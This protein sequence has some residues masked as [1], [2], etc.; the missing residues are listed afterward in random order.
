MAIAAVSMAAVPASAD[1]GRGKGKAH[2]DHRNGFTGH[3]PPGLAKKNPPCVPPGQAKRYGPGQVV[4]D[5]IYIRDP[6][7]YGLPGGG[8]Y[9]QAGNYVYRVDRDTMEVLNLVRAMADILN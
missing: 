9:V 5:Y 3:C 6:G 4:N 8:Y 2:G 1:P 7:R